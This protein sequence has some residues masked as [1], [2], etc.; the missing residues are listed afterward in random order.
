MKCYNFYKVI[1]FPILCTFTLSVLPKFHMRQCFPKGVT[2]FLEVSV[3]RKCVTLT[4][5][6]HKIRR[7]TQIFTFSRKGGIL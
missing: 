3:N 1:T 5:M 6:Y 7:V 2:N 4:E